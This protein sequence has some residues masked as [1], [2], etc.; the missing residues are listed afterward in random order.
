MDYGQR[1]QT[2]S[3][4]S[5]SPLAPDPRDVRMEDIAHALSLLC[6]FG[7]H[8]QRFYSVAEH[9]VRV[10]GM[11]PEQYQLWGLLHD[12]SEA[13]L[14]DVPSPIK[15]S[16]DFGFYREAEARVER[17]VAQR[18]GLWP[19]TMPP[20]VKQ[21]DLDVRSEE[22]HQLMSPVPA[23]AGERP[24]LTPCL[25]SWGWSP[26]QAERLWTSRFRQLTTRAVAELWSDAV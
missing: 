26:E 9:C 13:Y 2:Y 25:R 21:A 10:S 5:F 1:L 3:G 18:F 12:A 23:W 11:V 4:V 22:A 6:R 20:E 17:A 19:L 14:M 15:H 8:V 7:G 16:P 24:L